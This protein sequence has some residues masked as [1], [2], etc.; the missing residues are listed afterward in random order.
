MTVHTVTLAKAL[1]GPGCDCNIICVK[2]QKPQCH[3]VCCV[4][5]VESSACGYDK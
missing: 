3:E 1:L 4:V 2:Q 5:T